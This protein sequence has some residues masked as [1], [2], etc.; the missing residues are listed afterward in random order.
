MSMLFN[1]TFVSKNKGV[2]DT[3]QYNVII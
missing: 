3:V 1:I 2:I